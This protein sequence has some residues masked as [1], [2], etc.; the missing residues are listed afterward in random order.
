MTSIS[1]RVFGRLSN[2][3]SADIYTLT[4]R[5]GLCAKITNFGGVVVALQVPDK[6]GQLGDVVLGFDTLAPYEDISPYFGALIGPYGN[7]IA[8]AAF[9]LNGR[10]YQLQKND[11]SNCLHG[12]ERGFDKLL[13]AAE[14]GEVSGVP[15]LQLNYL[16]PDGEGGFPGNLQLRAEYRL[17]DTNE[18]TTCFFAVSDRASHV[19]FTQH[20]YFNLLGQGSVAQHKVQIDA[21]SYLPIDEN[22]IP[23]GE[24]AP[25]AESAFD[26]RKPKALGEGLQQGHLQTQRV[27]GGY[28]H[29][30]VLNKTAANA[31][32]RA[33]RVCEMQ[34]GRVL[35]VY[36]T[37]PGLQFYSGN[38]LD[39]S[40][41]GKQG[42]RYSKHSGFCLEPQ[43]FPDSPNQSQFP[44]TLL[45]PGE[46]FESQIGFKFSTQ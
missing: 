46:C 13:W 20:S 32:E 14:A 39:G 38:F 34:S 44:S 24:P 36:T 16:W 7:R 40:I 45:Q 22:F 27:N 29:N 19:N 10:Q 3:Q 31:Y 2:G 30:Y 41:C 37:E 5:H 11:G 43:H 4:N 12:G 42:Q 8:N 25:V 17:T 18:L 33:A 23:L 21:D 26:F 9:A 6:A 15:T 35:E 28:D 1:K